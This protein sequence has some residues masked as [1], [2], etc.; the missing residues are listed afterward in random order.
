[1]ST[2]AIPSTPVAMI[3]S[4]AAPWNTSKYCDNYVRT[5]PTVNRREP[6]AIDWHNTA[7]IVT[8]KFRYEIIQLP[9]PSLENEEDII[10]ETQATGL[11][12]IDWKSVEHN[13]CLPEFPW[14]TGREMAGV[15]RQV[16]SKVKGLKVGDRVWTSKPYDLLTREWGKTRLEVPVVLT[17][18]YNAD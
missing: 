16:G 14:V 12:P 6:P 10:I 15:I 9:C 8:S 2:I 18:F 5:A 4:V 11:N 17:Q 1:M 7:L 3:K 13:F